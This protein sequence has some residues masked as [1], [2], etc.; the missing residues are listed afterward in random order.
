MR[1]RTPNRPVRKVEIGG[2]QAAALQIKPIDGRAIHGSQPA[3]RTEMSI[4]GPERVKPVRATVEVDDDYAAGIDI[5][6][7]WSSLP[8]DR[9]H[10]A[11][12]SGDAALAVT[13]SEARA[14]A[15]A[16]RGHQHACSSRS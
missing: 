16:S 1:Q 11:P 14:V 5:W 2:H 8:P 12:P 4:A 10:R 6:F 9:H 3:H 13:T 7:H 15:A